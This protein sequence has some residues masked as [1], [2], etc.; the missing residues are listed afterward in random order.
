MENSADDCKDRACR[1][2]LGAAMAYRF[3][4][5]GVLL[6]GKNEDHERC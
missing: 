5:H 3:A 1:R 2:V 6:V 4:A